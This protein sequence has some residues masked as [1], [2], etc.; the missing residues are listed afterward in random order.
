[1]AYL[2]DTCWPLHDSEA[3]PVATSRLFSKSAQCSNRASMPRNFDVVTPFLAPRV[4]V[5][6]VLVPQENADL[7]AG[8]QMHWNRSLRAR[9]PRF[10]LPMRFPSDGLAA[11]LEFQGAQV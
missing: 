8:S 4:S 2:G 6:V 11:K 10:L 5:G 7:E 9:A 1:M 3:V